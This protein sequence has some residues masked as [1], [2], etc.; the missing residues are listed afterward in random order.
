MQKIDLHTMYIRLERYIHEID[1]Y[2]ANLSHRYPAIAKK[3]KLYRALD[4]EAKIE[5]KNRYISFKCPKCETK[6]KVFVKDY[7]LD[8]IEYCVLLCEKCKKKL[9]LKSSMLQNKEESIKL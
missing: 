5:N 6:N 1:R 2:I 3:Y 7:R 8:S 4:P 9:F